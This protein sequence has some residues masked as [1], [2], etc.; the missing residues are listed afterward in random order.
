ME[1]M[2]KGMEWDN[3]MHSE[4]AISKSEISYVQ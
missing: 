1:K 4:Q 3:T 2:W